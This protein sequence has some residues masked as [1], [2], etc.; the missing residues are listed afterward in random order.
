MQ[1]WAL[2]VDT[3]RESR[4]RRIFWLMLVMSILTAAVMASVTFE[5]GVVSI[6][7]GTWEVE[8]ERFTGPSGLRVDRISIIIVDYI[9]DLM[10]GFFG[11]ML[12]IV[13]SAGFI[14][15]MLERGGIE[16][17]VSKPL[18][19]WQIF[20]GK[21][22]GTLVFVLFQAAV[23]IGLTFLV[24]G[25]RWHAWLPGYLLCIPL[26]T[27]LFSYLYCITALMGL[28]Y[29]NALIAVLVTVG[30]WV[31][32]FGIQRLGDAFNAYPEWKEN[33]AL[34]YTVNTARW[35][36]PKTTDFTYIAR[37]WAGAADPTEIM[38]VPP[39]PDEEEMIERARQAEGERMRLS[40]WAVIGS[41][42]AFEAVIVALAMAYFCRRDL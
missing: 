14:P 17:V 3:F 15:S 20:L 7:F 12:A 13:A 40:A 28:L 26:V 25:L 6:L 36:V 21:Y 27:V 22:L 39:G 16:V 32:F 9:M 35:I 29:R 31:A 30:C 18:P 41:S 10:L 19:R 33:R 24:A 5:P 8:T 1:L 23:F 42:L 11:V 4:D 34:Y 37:R 38:P 2:I